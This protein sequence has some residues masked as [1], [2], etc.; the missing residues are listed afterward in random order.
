MRLLMLAVPMF[1]VAPFGAIAMN[2]LGAQGQWVQQLD[3][4]LLVCSAHNAAVNRAVE[5]ALL[6]FRME[7]KEGGDVLQACEHDLAFQAWFERDASGVI[8]RETARRVIREQL[9]QN[10]QRLRVEQVFGGDQSMVFIEHATA[11]A[12]SE[13]A[14]R[15]AE[16]LCD[17]G[18]QRR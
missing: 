1:V 8:T 6:E 18:F 2:D 10:G 3:H 12:E 16:H 5:S 14:A 7:A 11:Q 9:D 17:A 13:F 4:R 15:V